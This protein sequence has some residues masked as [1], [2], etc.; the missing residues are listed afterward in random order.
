MNGQP[1]LEERA[2]ARD[3]SQPLGLV[4][5]HGF[6]SSPSAWD[7]FVSL[8]NADPEFR[9]PIR[10]LQFQYATAMF[11]PWSPFTRL[12][13]L[14]TVAGSLRV[15][16]ETE[17]AKFDR[18]VLICHSQGGLVVQR[19]LAQ[20]V[21]SGRGNELA[22]IRR[23]ILFAC[24]NNGS[25]L[26][27]TLR[28][29]ILR[30]HPQ[31]Y[32]LRPLCEGVNEVQRTIMQQIVYTE[33]VAPHK[34]RITFAVYAGESDNI[35]EP[36]SAQ[37]VFPNAGSLP[38]DHFSIIR[39]DSLEHRSY[40]VLKHQ[41]C[42]ASTVSINPSPTPSPGDST[43]VCLSIA[44]DGHFI[45]GDHEATTDAVIALLERPFDQ[46]LV[47]IRTPDIE[48]TYK[49]TNPDAYMALQKGIRTYERAIHFLLCDS[50]RFT[51][52]WTRQQLIK[53]VLELRNFALPGLIDYDHEIWYVW[54]ATDPNLVTHVRIPE[55][56]ATFTR[57][58]YYHDD[59]MEG[60]RK[61]GLPPDEPIWLNVIFPNI[62]WE[63]I[64]PAAAFLA[65]EG[66][67]Q[68]PVYMQN[69]V[70]S[71]RNPSELQ[72]RRPRN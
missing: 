7:E 68:T 35:V 64:A 54:P 44:E 60:I 18:L 4:F 11:T 59:F 20:M 29:R 69:W 66:K 49:Y 27:L 47:S 65:A 45:G 52:K 61:Q 63:Q 8:L 15:F 46:R 36:V 16:L 71:D 72:R 28:R 17:A 42:L 38:G 62:F 23:V 5:V 48:P 22:R 10:C 70:I 53:S 25:E 21:R 19:F 56:M 31:E 51:S 12:P 55:R 40:R 1:E 67:L 2:G 32:Q 39:P 43:T 57:K 13:T 34:C 33:G 26:G 30:G 6:N 9:I 41:I 3:A 58:G 24:P 50:V 37:A 14:G